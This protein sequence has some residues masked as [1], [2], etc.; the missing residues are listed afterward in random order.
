[1]HTR[2]SAVFRGLRTI[3]FAQFPTGAGGDIPLEEFFRRRVMPCL[4]PLGLRHTNPE[5][6][7]DRARLA[8]SGFFEQRHLFA[9][10]GLTALRPAALSLYFIK[11]CL[12]CRFD[13]ALSAQFASFWQAGTS[14]VAMEFSNPAGEGGVPSRKACL[15]TKEATSES[16]WVSRLWDLSWKAV[17]K[18]LGASSKDVLSN[19]GPCCFQLFSVQGNSKPSSWLT[20]AVCIFYGFSH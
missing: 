1:M 9:V 3:E 19:L 11:V 17:C 20:M 15:E 16:V 5:E 13:M 12:A 10:L 14:L 6:A 8:R 18:C 4:R 2:G 7:W